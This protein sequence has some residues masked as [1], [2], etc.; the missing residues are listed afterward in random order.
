M[1]LATVMWGRYVGVLIL[2]ISSVLMAFFTA[3]SA[4]SPR[5]PSVRLSLLSMASTYA[6]TAVYSALLALRGDIHRP[7]IIGLL[8][9]LP[10]QA[11]YSVTIHSMPSTYGERADARLVAAM[12]GVVW[13]GLA[14]LLVDA[15]W[16]AAVLC[17]SP[18]LYFL[19]A[20]VYR[21]PVRLRKVLD[22]GPGPVRSS[23][24]YFLAGHIYAMASWVWLA[25]S[26]ILWLAGSVSLLA[27][28]HA[29][30]MGFIGIHIYIHAPLMLPVLLGTSTERRYGHAP[31]L[32]LLA[33]AMLWPVA[34]GPAMLLF[35]LSLAALL[36]V[37]KVRGVPRSLLIPM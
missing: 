12:H 32:L 16:G 31:L 5:G 30:V 13:L 7:E 8:Y 1:P 26:T 19:A 22:M 9:A 3:L 4:V 18:L 34:R 28:I 2:A 27:V 10:V 29:L 37:V 36:L 24:L 11:I 20:R 23:H 15:R 6:S 21:V 25:S 14:L 17:L 35:L 33:S